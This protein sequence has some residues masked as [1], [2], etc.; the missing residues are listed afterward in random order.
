MYINILL[1]IEKYKETLAC[2]KPSAPAEALVA[3][4]SIRK[5]LY[6]LIDKKKPYGFEGFSSEILP[7]FAL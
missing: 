4:R 3:L 1:N 5:K 6:F 7:N 2:A